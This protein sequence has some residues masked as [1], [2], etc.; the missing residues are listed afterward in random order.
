[1]AFARWDPFRDLLTLQERIDRLSGE[2][3]PGWA[4]PIDSYETADRYHEH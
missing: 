1:V 2:T 4:P 3:A